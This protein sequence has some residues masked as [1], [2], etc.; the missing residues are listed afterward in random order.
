MLSTW[1]CFLPAWEDN[2][3]NNEDLGKSHVSEWSTWLV[4]NCVIEIQLKSL[5]L[6]TRQHL[7]I[8]RLVFY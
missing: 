7:G 4:H 1:S 6:N 2:S 8:E 3:H 5:I